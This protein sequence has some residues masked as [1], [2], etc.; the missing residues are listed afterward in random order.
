MIVFGGNLET[1]PTTPDS[2]DVWVLANATS[3]AAKSSWVHLQPTGTPPAGRVFPNAVYDPTSNRMSI[4]GGGEG[5]TSPCENDVRVLTNANGNG[6]TPAWT[7][8]NPSGTAPAARGQAAAIYDPTSNRM[9]IFGGQNC[10][11]TLF[12]DTWVLTNANGLGG[13]PAWTQLAT[14]GTPPSPR[15][16]SSVGY[17]PA[18]NR[19]IVFS[20]GSSA[21][22]ADVWVLT[23]ANGL[24]GNPTWIQL[25]PA[26]TAP[27]P[28]VTHS[29]VY[30][31]TTNTL[32][33]FGG[34]TGTTP[35][36]QDTWVLSNANGVGS[37]PTWTQINPSGSFPTARGGH[38]AVY[39]PTTNGMTIF[40]GSANLN[41]GPAVLSDVFVLTNANT[42]GSAPQ[43]I[44]KSPAARVY[45]TAV[46][47]PQSDTMIVFGG[48]LETSPT[49][50]DSN[51]V[52]VLT[53][54]TNS[55]AVSSWTQLQPTGTPPAG[56]VFPN[57]VYDPTSNRMS[58]FGGGE[59]NTSPCENDV[60]GADQRQW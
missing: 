24:G 59:G 29:T 30:D 44:P 25:S 14:V 1:S 51:D 19:M 22:A 20:G 31:P 48:N 21:P 17:D 39:N 36:L 52:W 43:W 49:T 37:T 27:V 5:N 35:F 26:G 47:D 40:G 55:A 41:T 16:I 2:N 54:A 57:A 58:I 4:F 33:V 46:L 42:H 9:T 32:I 12:N 60:L 56:R 15:E 7:S 11:S 13:T 18:T 53:N 28:R 23:N 10:F 38:T 34:E 50:P 8:L 45:Q 3:S 6:G